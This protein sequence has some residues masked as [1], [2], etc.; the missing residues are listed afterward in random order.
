[1]DTADKADEVIKHQ[2]DTLEM[3]S[4]RITELETKLEAYENPTPTTAPASSL[5]SD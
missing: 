5:T 1:M 3:Q 4:A 2:A